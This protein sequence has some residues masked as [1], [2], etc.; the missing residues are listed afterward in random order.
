V[1]VSLDKD[2]AALFAKAQS[3]VSVAFPVHGE[4]G[5]SGEFT[6]DRDDPQRRVLAGLSSPND[7][8]PAHVLA[9]AVVTLEQLLAAVEQEADP[10]YW[11]AQR[12]PSATRTAADL[13][14]VDPGAVIVEARRAQAADVRAALDLAR[15]AFALATDGL[16]LPA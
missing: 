15:R 13:F 16:L 3:I 14:P 5:T 12:R 1:Q 4:I 9:L 7:P 10:A 6:F 8:K 2:E 11:D